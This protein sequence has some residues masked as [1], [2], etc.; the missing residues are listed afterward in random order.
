MLQARESGVDNSCILAG[1]EELRREWREAQNESGE[2][3]VM[4]VMDYVVGW[5]APHVRIS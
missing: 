2:D 4:D 3:A 1:L 5:C